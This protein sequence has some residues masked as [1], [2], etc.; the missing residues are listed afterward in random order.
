[1]C[2][3]NDSEEVAHSPDERSPPVHSDVIRYTAIPQRLIGPRSRAFLGLGLS[4]PLAP[5]TPPRHQPPWQLGGRAG[6]RGGEGS[7][8]MALGVVVARGEAMDAHGGRG[9]E[10]EQRKAVRDGL[11]L[12]LET[13][14]RPT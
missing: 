8:E 1:M 10:D 9:E 6:H 4:P 2:N 14:L 13:N 12:A 11:W 5:S 7:V 3:A